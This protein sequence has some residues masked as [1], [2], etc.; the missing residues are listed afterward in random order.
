MQMA[1]ASREDVERVMD[2]FRII[3]EF[4]EYGTHTPESDEVEEDSNDLTDEQ[5]VELLRKKWGGRFQ[6]PG[7]DGSWRRVV[8]GFQVVF[9]NCCD[10]ESDVLALRKDWQEAFSSQ[11]QAASGASP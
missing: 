10:K 8:H 6:P 3:E 9:D 11:S 4:M 5:F 1:A 7:V 2:F